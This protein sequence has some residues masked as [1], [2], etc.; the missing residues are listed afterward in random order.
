VNRCN[1]I[2]I[3]PFDDFCQGNCLRASIQGCGSAN[4]RYEKIPFSK[5]YFSPKIGSATKGEI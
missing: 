3:L 5:K 4:S 2:I 1:D